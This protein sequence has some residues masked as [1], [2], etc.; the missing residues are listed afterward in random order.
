MDDVAAGA[1]VDGS[2]D[3]PNMEDIVLCTFR[4]GSDVEANAVSSDRGLEHFL[5]RLT[6]LASSS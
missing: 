2:L 1:T 4:G 3:L 5:Q 6:L